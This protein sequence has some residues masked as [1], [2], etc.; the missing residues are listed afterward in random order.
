VQWIKRT[1]LGTD[2]SLPFSAEV[3]NARNDTTI[4]PIRLHSKKVKMS[5][6]LT[7]SALR[8]EGV[9]GSGCIDP[10]FLDFGTNWR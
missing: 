7:I 9:W 8:H 2:P 3:Q 1:G 5:L 6:Y 4:L 10:H